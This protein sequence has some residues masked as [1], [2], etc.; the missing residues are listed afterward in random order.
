MKNLN[1]KKNKIEINMMKPK[2]PISLVFEMQLCGCQPV[3]TKFLKFLDQF[4]KVFSKN[5]FIQ[6]QF[7]VM[8]FRKN[9]FTFIVLPKIYL[10]LNNQ[11]A[12]TPVEYKTLLILVH[13]IAIK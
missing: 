2:I 13:F 4:Q 6:S 3:R 1:N 8:V 9:K 11:D 10:N 12:T 5:K 7:E